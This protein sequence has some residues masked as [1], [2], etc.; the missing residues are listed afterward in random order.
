MVDFDLIVLK[1]IGFLG[2]LKYMEKL[3]IGLAHRPL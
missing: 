1:L 3:V 2:D